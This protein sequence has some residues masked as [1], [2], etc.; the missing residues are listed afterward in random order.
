MGLLLQGA[1][2]IY[3]IEANKKEESVRMISCRNCKIMWWL[4]DNILKEKILGVCMKVKKVFIATIVCL[5]ISFFLNMFIGALVHFCPKI[6]NV[7]DLPRIITEIIGLL[8][9]ILIIFLCR[10]KISI[11]NKKNIVAGLIYSLPLF[12]FSSDLFENKKL[13]ISSNI[14][15]FMELYEFL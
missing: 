5:A 12:L 3:I 15:F 4:G 6:M 10:Y 11:F 1:I 13:Y 7:P 14:T 9:V 2:A 8:I